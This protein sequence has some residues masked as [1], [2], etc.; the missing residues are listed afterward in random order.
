MKLIVAIVRDIEAD[1]V[2]SGLVERQFGVTRIAST[3]GFLRRGNTTFLIGTE[4]AKV[5]QALEIIRSA[6]SRSEEGTGQR[7]ATIFVL[8]VARF[9]QL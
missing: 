9:E 6:C 5:D 2:L 3:G 8:N 4:E 7:R 1:A